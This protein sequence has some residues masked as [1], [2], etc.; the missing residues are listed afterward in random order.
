MTK[1]R[2]LYIVATGRQ[3]LYDL[4]KKQFGDDP[5]V[6]VIFD[7]RQSERRAASGPTPEERRRK[8][9]RQFER[10]HLL[11]TLGV[12]LVSRDD[13]EAMHKSEATPAKAAS[14]GKRRK[15]KR[16]GKGA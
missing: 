15:T 5:N 3:S 13:W 9:R 11:K 1:R 16:R 8:D 14:A 4:L 2:D 6:E 12:V 10:A 7:R